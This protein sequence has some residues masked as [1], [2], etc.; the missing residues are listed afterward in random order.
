LTTYR[1]TVR[2]AP[3]GLLVLRNGDVLFKTEYTDDNGRPEVYVAL[4]GKRYGDGDD[5]DCVEATEAACEAARGQW[6]AP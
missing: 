1:M 2:N 6:E 3:P 5:V 4:S